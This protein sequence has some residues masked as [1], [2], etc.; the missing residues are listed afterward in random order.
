MAE[1]KCGY[2]RDTDN[3]CDGTHKIVNKIKKDMIAKIDS[4][5]FGEDNNQ[6]N[7]LGMRMSIVK[8]LEEK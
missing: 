5:P 7:A 2:T 1:C 8:T 3:N 6:L 4:I